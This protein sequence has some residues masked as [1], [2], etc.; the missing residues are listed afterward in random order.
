MPG[1]CHDFSAI[2]GGALGKKGSAQRLPVTVS[3]VRLVKHMDWQAA[4]L[5]IEEKPSLDG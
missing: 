5:P 3:F 1:D 4:G 2:V